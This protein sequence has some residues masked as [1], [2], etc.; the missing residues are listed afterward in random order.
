MG[1][2]IKRIDWDEW[3][4][5]RLIEALT[6]DKR[7]RAATVGASAHGTILDSQRLTIIGVSRNSRGFN[8]R[9]T[10]NKLYV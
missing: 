6:M 5:R 3:D 9:H 8:S 4:D 1:G 7:A 2:R 10:T